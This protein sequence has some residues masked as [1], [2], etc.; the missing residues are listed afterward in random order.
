MTPGFD[1][2]GCDYTQDEPVLSA[3]MEHAAVT[4]HMLIHLVDDEGTTVTVSATYVLSPDCRDGNCSK[5][6]GD[7]WDLERDCLTRCS[8]PHH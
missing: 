5:C 4:G 6:N 3:A 7:A 1:C 8:C 2:Q